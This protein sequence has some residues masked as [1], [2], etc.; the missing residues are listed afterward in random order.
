MHKE[1]GEIYQKRRRE[2][3]PNRGCHQST[4]GTH[5]HASGRFGTSVVGLWGKVRVSSAFHPSG[6]GLPGGNSQALPRASKLR[7]HHSKPEGYCS[8]TLVTVITAILEAVS[9][10]QG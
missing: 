8:G 6:V 10:P 3:G 1:F 5:I 4:G 7:S 2:L 9:S